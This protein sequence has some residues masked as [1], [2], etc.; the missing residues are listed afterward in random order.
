MKKFHIFGAG[1]GGLS[2]AHLLGKKYPT[3]QIIVYEKKDIVGGQAR[4]TRDIDGKFQEYCWHAFGTAYKHLFELLE[5]VGVKKNLVPVGK[6]IYDSEFLPHFIEYNQNFLGSGNLIKVKNAFEAQ[7]VVFTF[8]D[9]I[10]MIK[11]YLQIN[12]IPFLNK[13]AFDKEDDIS[14]KEFVKDIKDPKLQNWLIGFPSIYLGME[15]CQVSAGTILNIARSSTGSDHTYDF[16]IPNG[17]INEKILEPWVE[18]L[19]NK[20]NVNIM[21]NTE[22]KK[23][24]VNNDLI[25]K[26]HFYN[27]DSIELIPGL[28]TVINSMDVGGW[29]NLI[30]DM[31]L[32][33]PKFTEYKVK[34]RDL[35]LKSYQIQTQILFELNEYID[36]Q[37]DN[38]ILLI[39]MES[40][41]CLMTRVE[42]NIWTTQEGELLSCGI[43]RWDVPSELYDRLPINM[44]P[45]E[46]AKECWHQMCKYGK[47]LF[48]SI[49]KGKISKLPIKEIGYKDFRYWPYSYYEE[50]LQTDEPKFSNNVGCLKLR[51]HIKDNYFSNVYHVNAYTKQKNYKYQNPD[52][53]CMENA[54]AIAFKAIEQL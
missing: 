14:W 3:A 11:I 18:F 27:K 9:A 32:S 16:M 42:S 46:I 19:K 48:G 52:L 24:E 8:W 35:R 13:V 21:L 45:E 7:G 51:P 6:Y 54:A 5:E 36:W 53:F 43:G 38:G 39:F 41:W 49:A 4:S 2:I 28:D 31:D 17:P 10:E 33:N 20:Y 34:W 15:A 50:M 47:N 44:S 25:T 22:I 30:H 29:T 12:K 26:I 40:P 37:E 23:L 1:I